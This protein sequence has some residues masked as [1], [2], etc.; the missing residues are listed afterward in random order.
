MEL[1]IQSKIA[2]GNYMAREVFEAISW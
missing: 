2:S 1:N